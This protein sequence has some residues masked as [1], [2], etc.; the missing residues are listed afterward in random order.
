MRHRN[1]SNI[2]ICISGRHAQSP[3]RLLC[4]GT[5]GLATFIFSNWELKMVETGVRGRDRQIH[6]MPIRRSKDTIYE[7]IYLYGQ[8]QCPRNVTLMRLASLLERDNSG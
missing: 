8:L 1:A 6:S 3:E 4:Y 2:W 7:K 5:R